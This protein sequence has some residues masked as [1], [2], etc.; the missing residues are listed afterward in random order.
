MDYVFKQIA[1]INHKPFGCNFNNLLLVEE[2]KTGFLSEFLFTCNMCH[3][4]EVYKSENPS[5]SLM[6][7]NTSI[8]TAVINSEQ[9]FTQLETFSAILNMHSMYN[10]L[11]Q[12]LH[13]DVHKFTSET[14][15]EAMSLAAE[16]EAKLA[17]ANGDVREDGVPMITVIADGTWSKRSYKSNYNVLSGVVRRNY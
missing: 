16:E 9:G 14:A 5:S 3:R 15:W 1:E 8:V 2:R 7:V 17:V 11:Y 4:H 10:K 13:K 12:K 6:D